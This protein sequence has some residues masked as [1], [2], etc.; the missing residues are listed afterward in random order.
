MIRDINKEIIEFEKESKR[1]MD[2]ILKDIKALMDSSNE[3]TEIYKRLV[4]TDVKM[5][6]QPT[7][8]WLD[9]CP[10]LRA[11]KQQEDE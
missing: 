4:G 9:W 3:K 1:H 8:S 7:K 11:R 6:K 2:K 5:T 10:F